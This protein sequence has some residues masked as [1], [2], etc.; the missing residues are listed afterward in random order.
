MESE[1]TLQREVEKTR[2]E[3]RA[4][5]KKR[6]ELHVVN[7]ESKVELHEWYFY[8]NR[9]LNFHYFV[10]DMPLK[11]NTENF[12]CR[13]LDAVHS[14][15]RKFASSYNKKKVSPA[16]NRTTVRSDVRFSAT[17]NFFF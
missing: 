16:K 3:K 5:E 10:I 1:A 4:E 15:Q 11:L 17:E 9:K 13:F 7:I 6:I 8:L 12:H 14:T 2:G